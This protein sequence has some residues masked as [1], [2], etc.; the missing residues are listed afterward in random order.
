VHP[1]GGMFH[2]TDT[3]RRFRPVPGSCALTD[4]A[5]G[6]VALI[7]NGE[8]TDGDGWKGAPMDWKMIEADAMAKLLAATEKRVTDSLPR[9]MLKFRSPKKEGGGDYS[10]HSRRSYSDSGEEGG[11]T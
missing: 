8:M 7:M 9:V 6:A 3:N 5:G 11:A 10:R 2:V 1:A 4:S